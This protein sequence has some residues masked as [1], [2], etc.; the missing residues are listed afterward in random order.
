MTC[1]TASALPLLASGTGLAGLACSL[2][3]ASAVTLS[4]AAAFPAVLENLQ[5]TIDLNCAGACPVRVAAVSWG[6]FPPDLLSADPP[7]LIL[8]ADCL[9]HSQGAGQTGRTVRRG[10][11][12]AVCVQRGSSATSG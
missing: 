3:G 5:R 7:E 11:T 2:C 1:H 12:Q 10:S 6:L 4:D 9:Y 8:A